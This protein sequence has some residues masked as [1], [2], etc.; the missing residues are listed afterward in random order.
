VRQRLYL[1]TSVLNRPFDDQA[2][3][4][5]KLETEA[6]LAVLEKI[7]AG[8]FD[9]VGSSVLDFEAEANPSAERQ[10][11]VQSYLKV[12]THF[13]QADKKLKNRANQI[14]TLGFK[15][16]DALHRAAAERSAEVFLTA[17]DR[18]LKNALKSADRLGV[19]V[20]NPIHFVLSEEFI[21]A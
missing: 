15:A 9:L 8:T 16:I 17:D 13:V 12:A 11:R 2:Q 5:I 19:K 10:E 14:A 7:E 1:D 21:N 3:A 18:L 4:R 20:M 6:F